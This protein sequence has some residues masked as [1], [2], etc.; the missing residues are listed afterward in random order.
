MM[1]AHPL[2]LTGSLLCAAASGRLLLAA[3]E[4]GKPSAV[5]AWL[6]AAAFALWSALAVVGALAG[7]YLL[8]SAEREG[9]QQ[10]AWRAVA[11]F[12]PCAVLAALLFW[13]WGL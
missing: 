10:R 9:N 8:L 4:V 13:G 5:I 6:S 3:M 7:G 12:A 11:L 2:W 1:A